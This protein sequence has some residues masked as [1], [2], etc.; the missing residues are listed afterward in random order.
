MYNICT[1]VSI[2]LSLDDAVVHELS[3]SITESAS[4]PIYRVKPK[5]MHRQHIWDNAIIIIILFILYSAISINVHSAV[6]KTNAPIVQIK[7]I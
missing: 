6:H 4:M 5:F 1:N 7:P 2:Y 3:V